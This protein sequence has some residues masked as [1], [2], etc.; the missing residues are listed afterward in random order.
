MARVGRGRRARW[1]RSEAKVNLKVVTISG[2]ASEVPRRWAACLSPDAEE[3]QFSSRPPLDTL[4]SAHPPSPTATAVSTVL[5]VPA[6]HCLRPYIYIFLFCSLLDP[7]EKKT[8]RSLFIS[9]I[10]LLPPGVPPFSSVTR[11]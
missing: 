11:H 4:L 2:T 8:T 1:R 10:L 9:F 5:I 6:V 3:P 7:R